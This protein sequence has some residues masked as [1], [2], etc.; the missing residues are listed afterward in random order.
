MERAKVKGTHVLMA[1]QWIDAQLGEGEFLKRI[2]ER[3]S[4][5]PKVL[6]P[7]SWY[8]V[9]PMNH[10][11]RSA[12]RALGRTVEDVATD[13]SRSNAR[14]DLTT[15]Y[16]AFLRVAG[17]H[18]VMNATALLWRNYVNFGDAQKV[19]NERGHYV[20]E[21]RGIP[22]RLLEWAC[23]AWL[24]FVPT[25][26]ELAGGKRCSARIVETRVETSELSALRMEVRY[27]M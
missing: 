25:A 17:P 16:R 23:G 9:D 7:A 6:L 26:I 3:P 18:L 14:H 27:A 12:A 5:W 4:D 20:G 22:T 10:A 21:C 24:G 15:V 13:I 11:L 8:D 19:V 1:R 2:E